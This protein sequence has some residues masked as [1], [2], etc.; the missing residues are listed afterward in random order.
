[1]DNHG[2]VLQA[3]AEHDPAKAEKAVRTLLDQTERLYREAS[4]NR[5][6]G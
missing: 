2:A 4:E 6:R 3:I 5:H 1:M